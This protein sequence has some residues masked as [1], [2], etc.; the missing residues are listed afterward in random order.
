M[1]FYGKYFF[2]IKIKQHLDDHPNAESLSSQTD[3]IIESIPHQE[4]FKTFNKWLERM[5][6]F[7][8][9]KGDYF[10]HLKNKI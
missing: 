3:E 5:R 10:E 4:Y 9:N 6:L 1:S 7:V 2:S 8:E